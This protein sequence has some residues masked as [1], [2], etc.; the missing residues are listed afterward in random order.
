[1]K[2]KIVVGLGLLVVTWALRA[3]EIAGIGVELK[4]LGEGQ[5][6]R[7]NRLIPGGP[8]AKAGISPGSLLLSVNGTNTVGMRL[9]E[10]VALVRGEEGTK[11]T[12]EIADHE[13]TNQIMLTREKIVFTK[14]AETENR[15]SLS[16]TTNDVLFIQ[17]PSGA[18]AVVQFTSFG[19]DTASYRWRYRAAKSEPIQSGVGSVRESYDRKSKGDAGYEVMPKAGHNTTIRAGG[20]ILEW[21]Y[22]STSMGWVYHDGIGAAIQVFGVDAFDMDLWFKSGSTTLPRQP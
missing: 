7:I 11:V 3:G 6:Q 5:P 1:M 9:V 16:V 4:A 13:R 2:R 12:L 18:A 10:C 15:K 21:S 14:A 20:I 17:M 8:A 22:G 19:P